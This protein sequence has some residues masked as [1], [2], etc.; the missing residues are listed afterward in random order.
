MCWWK[1]L[2]SSRY[3]G[4]RARERG[5]RRDRGSVTSLSGRCVVVVGDDTSVRQRKFVSDVRTTLL[6]SKM[7]KR[8][9]PCESPSPPC[10]LP[11][12]PGRGR[13]AKALRLIPL[14]QVQ[15]LLNQRLVMNA[16]RL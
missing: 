9:G 15:D 5:S 16:G 6:H 14:P 10:P 12:V 2:P 8:R 7:A 3:A 11:G 13:S 4:E 1:C